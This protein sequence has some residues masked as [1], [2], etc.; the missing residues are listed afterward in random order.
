MKN[1]EVDHGAAVDVEPVTLGRLARTLKMYRVPI[2]V[3]LSAVICG[4]VIIAAC[5]FVTA[6]SEIVTSQPF[7][8]DFEG[9]TVGRY[10]NGTKFTP[11][12]IVSAPILARVYEAN[13]LGRF[14]PFVVF[15]K[16]V[17]VV[18]ANPAME[19]L[20]REFQARL[21][22][23]KLSPLDRDRIVREF[24]S[25]K[26][27][28]SKNEYSLNF[29][30]ARPEHRPPS[31]TVKKVLSDIL[32][33]W[34]A[35]AA[36]EQR[37]LQYQVAV[38]SPNM[39]PAAQDHSPNFIRRVLTL[40]SGIYRIQDN[41]QQI[42]RLPGGKM[43]RTASDQLTLNDI[44]LNLED[45]VRFRLEPLVP[46]IR[47]SGLIPN[48]AEA[49]SF[50]HAQLAHDER[51]L[52]LA[53]ARAE[54]IRQSIITYAGGATD[55]PGSADPAT[56]RADGVQTRDA[57]TP[58]L[59]ENFLDRLIAMTEASADMTYRQRLV[60]E[61]R[62]AAIAVTPYEATVAYHR[63]MLAQL[64]NAPSGGGTVSAA[65]VEQQL[66]AIQG[67]VHL[68][69]RKL[70]ELYATISKSLQPDK[71]MFSTTGVATTRSQRTVRPQQLAGI[72]VLVVFLALPLILLAVL[73][74]SRVRQETEG[75][76]RSVVTTA[77]A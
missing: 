77:T 12:E 21:A 25:R 43:A 41:I 64:R 48:M 17:Y 5:I 73:I 59:S 16:S 15:T 37:V 32:R 4:Y 38:L 56:V 2:L 45:I 13:E 67:E 60:D 24:E 74:H 42:E 61:Y 49:I 44:R 70:N 34:A 30:A 31:G 71:Y 26:E 76:E 22:D 66:T 28:I 58:Q 46:A 57:V 36:R 75:E 50:A 62:D 55:G 23:P 35:Y 27:S 51:Y 68:A 29:S 39:V 63:E 1:D 18:E 14:L 69:L 54:V 10:P 11:S 19:R 8:L 52:T 72:G 3:S 9:A 33:E 47:A 53:R 65:E 6:P 40:R 7:R 20:T